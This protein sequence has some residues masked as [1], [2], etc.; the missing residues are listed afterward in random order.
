MNPTAANQGQRSHGNE[1]PQKNSLK[2]WSD[3]YFPESLHRESCA[4]QKE[5]N[6]QTDDPKML[7]YRVRRLED[8]QIGVGY[9]RQTKEQNEP[10]PLDARLALVGDCGS[11]RQ[12]YNPKR[13]FVC[14]R[15]GGCDT[16]QDVPNS[17][18]KCGNAHSLKNDNLEYKARH[19]RV[20]E[21]TKS[22]YGA[23]G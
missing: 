16:V 7:E 1:D 20:P 5:R 18:S 13:P 10:G 8:V 22:E 23:V 6:G 4:N 15:N 17:A 9:R 2:E 3:A 12:R 11:E 14:P 19:L 21:H